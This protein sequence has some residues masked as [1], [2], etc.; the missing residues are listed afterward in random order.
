MNPGQITARLSMREIEIWQI[1][2]RRTMRRR[3]RRANK[4]TR[5]VVNL[6]RSYEQ[7]FK[8]NLDAL[9]RA[10]APEWKPWMERRCDG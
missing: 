3:A 6:R 9:A 10:D 2:R 1:K 4:A 5:Y 8:D 7:L